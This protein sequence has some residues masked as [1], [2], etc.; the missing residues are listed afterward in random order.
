VNEAVTPTPA[1]TTADDDNVAGSNRPFAL[2]SH[3]PAA[4][5]EDQVVAL[6]SE[7]S[8][9]ADAGLEGCRCNFSLGD[10][11]LLIRRELAHRPTLP[12]APDERRL[13]GQR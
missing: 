5:V 12:T 6:V 1:S 9:D 4:R 3:Q 10:C 8:R 2:N 13:F 7:R 11:T